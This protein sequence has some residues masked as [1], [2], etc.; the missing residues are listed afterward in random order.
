MQ[1]KKIIKNIKLDYYQFIK[2]HIRNIKEDFKIDWIIKELKVFDEDLTTIYKDY[3]IY[4]NKDGE[5]YHIDVSKFI[6]GIKKRVDGFYPILSEEAGNENKI[7]E[8]LKKM[9]D[10]KDYE[11]YF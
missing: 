5:T 8:E 2:Y 9:E 10:F 3:G 4:F 11:I 6:E 1:A 7:L